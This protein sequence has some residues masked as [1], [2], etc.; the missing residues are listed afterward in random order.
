MDLKTEDVPAVLSNYYRCLLGIS[1]NA[2]RRLLVAPEQ[3]HLP[4][5]SCRKHGSQNT[6]YRGVRR[7]VSRAESSTYI[8]ESNST[9]VA[10]LTTYVRPSCFRDRTHRL[11]LE[12][13]KDR[14]ISL[15][16]MGEH[17]L[18]SFTPV[19]HKRKPADFFTFLCTHNPKKW[20]SKIVGRFSRL[21]LLLVLYFSLRIF[22]VISLLKIK[23]TMAIST[24]P[25]GFGDTLELVGR[26]RMEL[27]L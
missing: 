26:Q 23:N 15:A 7:S 6:E 25:L 3:N 17:S 12:R 9:P 4:A 2:S 1:R 22:I 16:R 27:T 14:E 18:S 8:R 19:L 5:R 24:H 10:V 11:S 13:E 20:K 21:K